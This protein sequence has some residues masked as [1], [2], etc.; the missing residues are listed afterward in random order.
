VLEALWDE[1]WMTLRPRPRPTP[2]AD[3][4]QLDALDEAAERAGIAVVD[5]VRRRAFG[6]GG[7]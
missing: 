3:P 5:A 2:Y 6:L 7:R 4:D 1:E